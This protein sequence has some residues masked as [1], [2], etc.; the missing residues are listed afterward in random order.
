MDKQRNHDMQ[1]GG[2]ERKLQYRRT[3]KNAPKT[4]LVEPSVVFVGTA[5]NRKLKD[6]S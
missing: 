5:A 3:S 2:V 6:R 1:N 4:T